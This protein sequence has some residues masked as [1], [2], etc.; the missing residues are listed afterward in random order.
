MSDSSRRDFFRN[1]FLLSGTMVLPSPLWGQEPAR[2]RR[3]RSPYAPFRMGVQSYSLRHFKAEDALKHTKDLGVTF[4]EGWDGHFPMT[5]DP[6]KIAEY[7]ELLK[8]YNVRMPTYGVVSFGSKEDEARKR[9]EFAKAMGIET[10]SAAPTPDALP[11]VDKLVK[12]YS[13]NIAIHN[14]GPEDAQYGKVEQVLNAVKKWDSRL[15]ACNDTGHFLRAGEDPV[16]G[17]EL[18]DKRLFGVHLKNTKK[19]EDGSIG[20]TEIGAPGGMLDTT[21]LFAVLRKLNYRGVVALEYEEHEDN[22]VPFMAQCL[23]A[24]RRAIA[25]SRPKRS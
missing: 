5:D 16:K 3:Q 8:T 19:N 25:D 20:F 4:W 11:L 6:K 18:F 23:E 17:C 24:T 9:F 1:A 14:H 13:I 21:A 7:K 2:Q 22:P 10:L 15:G 12:E